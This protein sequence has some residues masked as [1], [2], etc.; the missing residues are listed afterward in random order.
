MA[1]GVLIWGKSHLSITQN[2]KNDHF[3]SVFDQFL[4]PVAMAT[5][6]NFQNTHEW[7]PT[8]ESFNMIPH[9]TWSDTDLIKWLILSHI[10]DRL[11]IC[12]IVI[13]KGLYFI[14]KIF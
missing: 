10:V 14:P 5:T 7:T 4:A 12:S 1:W 9:L 2:Y 11:R 13:F 8:V 3:S 6:E